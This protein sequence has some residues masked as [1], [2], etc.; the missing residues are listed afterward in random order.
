M[1]I[2]LKRHKDVLFSMS[3]RC[4]LFNVIKT[5]YFLRLT[6]ISFSTLIIGSCIDNKKTAVFLS[7]LLGHLSNSGDLL[8]WVGVRRRPLSVNI[9]F[10]RTTKLLRV[11]NW[12]FHDPPPPPPRGN[13][14]GEKKVKLIWKWIILL[15][16]FFISRK[17]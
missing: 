11:R 14:L 1:L 5:S 17:F 15:K 13:S 6:D 10:S 7:W 4:Q 8:L 9:F 12:K 16:F 2:Y 3:K